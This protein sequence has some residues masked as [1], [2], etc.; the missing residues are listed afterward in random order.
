[1]E[2]QILKGNEVYKYLGLLN[3]KA[4]NTHDITKYTFLYFLFSFSLLYL[5]S[6]KLWYLGS[7]TESKHLGLKVDVENSN[8]T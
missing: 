8:Q 4:Y 2:L 3:N 5:I 1:M 6:M 7:A